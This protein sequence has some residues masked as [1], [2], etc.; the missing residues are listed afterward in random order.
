[1]S[2]TATIV[3]LLLNGLAFG[4]L[5]FLFAS[6]LSL[7]FGLMGVVN[8]AHGALYMMGAY[9]GL[10]IYQQTFGTGL[11]IVA[12]LIAPFAVMGISMLIERFTLR[13]LY[14]VDILYQVLLT[15]G[16]AV[17]LE[18]AFRL[19]F[20]PVTLSFP[21]P[22]LLKGSISFGGVIFPYYRLFVIIVGAI[23]AVA[24][25]LFLERTR[26]G[27]IAR[28][29]MMNRDMVEANGINI[30]RAYTFMFGIGGF[31]AGLSGIMAAPMFGVFPTM[32]HDLILLG[33]VIVVIG[34][35]GSYK[36]SI[37]GAL[38]V[39]LAET[40]GNFFA[41]EIASVTLFALMVLVLLF[42]PSGMFGKPGVLA[43]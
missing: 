30:D 11:F 34:G 42:K 5:Y 28:A 33:F 26:Y 35:L 15:F 39:A 6:G 31:L 14:D 21:T 8:F 24:L 27:L 4:M 38:V 2:S 37:V 32:G 36:G 7:V 40:Y 20:G 25:Y 43:H 3:S 22:G 18:G 29:G 12:F 16:L 41:P 13:H 23:V 1:M 10:L 19:V 17:I 9:I